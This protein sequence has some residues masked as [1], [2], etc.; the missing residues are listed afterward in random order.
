[1]SKRKGLLST[2]AESTMRW[3]YAQYCM[4]VD[5]AHLNACHIGMEIKTKRVIY[6]GRGY[7]TM[8]KWSFE[9]V[10][11]QSQNIWVARRTELQKQRE[12]HVHLA[13]QNRPKIDPKAVWMGIMFRTSILRVG[14]RWEEGWIAPGTPT[15]LLGYIKLLKVSSSIWTARH[16]SLARCVRTKPEMYSS[17]L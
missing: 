9:K 12:K 14:P 7:R 2:Q 11:T 17:F 3:V 13:S 4:R 10:S 1:M 6:S 5:M 15:R 16:S 8:Q